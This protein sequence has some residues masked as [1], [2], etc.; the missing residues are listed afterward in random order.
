LQPIPAFR[1]ARALA[2]PESREVAAMDPAPMIEL[3]GLLLAMLVSTLPSRRMAS[4][5]P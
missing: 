1:I 2:S 5:L 3:L 4:T